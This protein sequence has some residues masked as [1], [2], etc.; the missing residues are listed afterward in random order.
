MAVGHMKG[1]EDRTLAEAALARLLRIKGERGSVPADEVKAAAQMAG[2]GESTIREWVRLGRVPQNSRA[3]G[4]TL[5]GEAMLSLAMRDGKPKRTHELLEKRGVAVPPL[6][7]FQRGV[8]RVEA[9]DLAYLREGSDGFKKTTVYLSYP[10][11]EP[12]EWFELDASLLPIE[13]LPAQG[14][15]TFRPWIVAVRE[16]FCGAVRG[17]ALTVERPHRGD[18]L[19]ALGRALRRNGVLGPFYGVPRVLV[20][21][22]ARKFLAKSVNN[23]AR[24]MKARPMPAPAFSPERK[25]FIETLFSIMDSEFFP[26]MPGHTDRPERADGVRYGAKK[27][28]FLLRHLAVELDTY[29]RHF[30]NERPRSQADPRPPA[31]IWDEFEGPIRELTD[32]EIRAFTMERRPVKVTSKGIVVDG[33]AFVYPGIR[34]HWHREFWIRMRPHDYRDIDVY[35]EEDRFLRNALRKDD[36]PQELAQQILKERQEDR[37]RLGRLRSDA[38]REETRIANERIRWVSLGD[39]T[40]DPVVDT[41]LSKRELEAERRRRQSPLE[42]RRELRKSDP[43]G[44]ADRLNRARDPD[45]RDENGSTRDG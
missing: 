11:N 4:Y 3:D 43:L 45:S 34:R 10:L 8:T 6:R 1:F 38:S 15:K 2:R 18:V 16:P 29:F 17:F 44:Y 37:K 35:D 7:T 26:G 31:Q 20:W 32:A 30:N 39:G 5:D 14:H 22:N 28:K 21:D 13:V 23:A 12:N 27:P 40:Q 33:V 25:P 36:L 24:M 41:R 19:G 9:G 42:A